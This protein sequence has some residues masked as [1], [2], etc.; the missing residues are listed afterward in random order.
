M[1][2]QANFFY[3]KLKYL[4][5]PQNWGWNKHIKFAH[6]DT[7]WHKQRE[8]T[9]SPD[10]DIQ[11]L[12]IWELF[13]KS[14][15]SVV[16]GDC[17]NDMGDKWTDTECYQNSGF[18]TDPNWTNFSV[19]FIEIF[20]IL[21]TEEPIRNLVCRDTKEQKEQTYLRDSLFLHWPLEFSVWG[22]WG[23]FHQFNLSHSENDSVENNICR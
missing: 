13:S 3:R 6:Y 20:L 15:P 22:V 8:N 9:R 12:R 21:Y 2:N 19:T 18:S 5:I 1:W 10:F 4:P 7:K 17:H 11:V 23:E 16:K 14:H